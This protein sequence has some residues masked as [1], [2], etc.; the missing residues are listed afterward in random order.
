MERIIIHWTAGQ[1]SPNAD[2][3]QHYHFLYG[4]GLK[5]NGIFKPEDNINCNDNKYAAHTGGLNTNSIGVAL[6]GMLGFDSKTKETKYPI[7]NIDIENMCQDVAKLCKKYK[8]SINNKHIMTHFEIGQK[9][10]NGEIKRTQL[11]AANIGKID[12]I[13]LHCHPKIG[14]F[15]IGD[16]LRNKIKWY[17][18]KL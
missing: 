4:K 16:F 11:T 8:I 12:I 9:V 7:Q 17:Y 15:Q 2:D 3:L 1:N 6:C 10:I 13:Y 18:D 5:F 14:T